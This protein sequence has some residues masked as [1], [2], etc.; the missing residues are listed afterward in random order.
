MVYYHVINF[1]LCK[2]LLNYG[3]NEWCKLYLFMSVY[4][5]LSRNCSSISSASLTVKMNSF[6]TA[7]EKAHSVL[8][9]PWVLN[10]PPAF[11]KTNEDTEMNRNCA[12]SEGRPANYPCKSKCLNVSHKLFGKCKNTFKYLIPC[13]NWQPLYTWNFQ[14]MLKSLSCAQSC[15]TQD[16]LC[17]TCIIATQ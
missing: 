4:Y 12:Q 9:G 15:S 16:H 8:C 6:R 1:F 10:L 3:H 17:Y 2:N 5:C 11:A 14:F 7:T 13:L